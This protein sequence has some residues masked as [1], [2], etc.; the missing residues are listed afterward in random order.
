MGIN[1][2]YSS[3]A[4]AQ[5]SPAALAPPSA[6][7]DPARTLLV[8][9]PVD[10]FEETVPAFREKALSLLNDFHLQLDLEMKET[11]LVDSCGLGALISLRKVM[12]ARGGK[13][14]LLNPCPSV[15]QIIVLTRLHHIFEIVTC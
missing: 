7:I 5:S 14:R 9:T 13:V 6:D 8:S 12:I 15:L 2:Q 3:S 4:V 10:M 11:V 1:R